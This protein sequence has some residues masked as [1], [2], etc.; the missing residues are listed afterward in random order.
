VVEECDWPKH[1]IPLSTGPSTFSLLL[2]RPSH[3]RVDVRNEDVA[4]LGR[5]ATMRDPRPLAMRSKAF[6][7]KDDKRFG[8]STVLAQLC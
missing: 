7:V 2:H 6:T 4:F 1:V 8:V 3:S 5:T